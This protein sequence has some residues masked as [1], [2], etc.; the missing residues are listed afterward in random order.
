MD[1]PRSHGCALTLA[2][3]PPCALLL[4]EGERFE[5]P[6]SDVIDTHYLS[7]AISNK[8]VLTSTRIH[9][10]AVCVWGGC[11]WVGGSVWRGVGCGWLGEISACT[12]T[13]SHSSISNKRASCSPAHPS[14]DPIARDGGLLAP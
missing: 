3:P 10:G 2:V 11:V 1:A 8:Q 6:M 5:V 12:R 4:Q 7:L 9:L 13:T 14:G